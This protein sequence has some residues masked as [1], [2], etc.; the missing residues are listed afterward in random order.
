[1]IRKELSAMPAEKVNHVKL[2]ALR[3]VLYDEIVPFLEYD[4]ELSVDDLSVVEMISDV[5]GKQGQI[6]RVHIM[7]DTGMGRAGFFYEESKDCLQK[8]LTLSNISVVALCSHMASAE[9][10][11][12]SL[13]SADLQLFERQRAEFRRLFEAMPVHNVDLTAYME[14][15][16]NSAVLIR[17]D[18]AFQLGMVR[19]GS[20]SY[21]LPTC[22]Y[23]SYAPPFLKCRQIFE[24]V[25]EICLVRQ[26]G[27]GRSVGYDKTYVTTSKT[28]LATLP[29]G[30]A[31]GFLRQWSGGKQSVWISGVECP[32]VGRVSQNMITVDV[33]AVDPIPSVGTKVEI[34]GGN[35]KVED[36]IKACNNNCS[37]VT[38]MSGVMHSNYAQYRQTLW[39]KKLSQ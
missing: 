32:V 10:P 39:P 20:I 28:W 6:A 26:L 9:D 1:M 5:A 23:S 19:V 7:L 37:E 17:G 3:P 16:A 21:G 15:V 11:D 4:V 22:P 35:F 27:V 36:V 24:W 33:T 2:L 38:I 12:W 14:H 25:T 8:L 29:I 31:D 13:C 18:K 30:F 34:A